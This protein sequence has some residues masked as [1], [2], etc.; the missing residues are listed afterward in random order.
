MRGCGGLSCVGPWWSG[1]PGRGSFLG[2]V[3][4][5]GGRLLGG[6]SGEPVVVDVLEALLSSGMGRSRSTVH[7][8]PDRSAGQGRRVAATPAPL[9]GLAAGVVAWSVWSGGG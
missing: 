2:D 6:E 7:L 5:G 3:V 8:H 4:S 1:L 9:S